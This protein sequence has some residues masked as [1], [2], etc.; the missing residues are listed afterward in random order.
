MNATVRLK[1]SLMLV[2]LTTL[3]WCGLP[4]NGQNSNSGS[5]DTSKAQLANFDRF[6]D[7]HAEIAE[8]LRKD[9]SLVKNP[10][11]R[12]KHPALREYWQEHPEIREEISENPNAFMR[13]EE[14]YDRHEED[15]DGDIRHRQLASFDRFLDGHPEVA[16]QLRKDPSLVKNEEFREKHPA[17]QEYWQQHPEVREEISENPNAFMKQEERFDR[18]EEDRDHDRDLDGFGHFLEGHS[19]IAQQLSRNPK[20]ANSQEFVSSHPELQVYL[21]ANP[22]VKHQLTEN[23]GAVLTRVQPMNQNR[24]VK[25]FGT[26]PVPKQ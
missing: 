14:R 13:Q 2:T 9:P 3:I 5:N 6:L 26:E 1:R 19:A 24:A 15:R 11:F 12:E 25:T 23:A 21:D 17:L 18:H 10:E 22:S 4:A 8:Q 20:L 7:N 16:E